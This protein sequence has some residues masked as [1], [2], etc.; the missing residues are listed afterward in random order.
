MLESPIVFNSLTLNDQAERDFTAEDALGYWY[1]VTSVDGVYDQDVRF[2]AHDL[3][4]QHGAKSGSAFYSGKTI[5]I[6]GE[7]RAVNLEKLRVAQ[8]ELQ[9]AF[10]DMQ[11][12]RLEF[13]LWE[14]EA[15]YI[16]CR[17]NQK[18]DMTEEQDTPSFLRRFTIQLFADDPRMYKQEGDTVYPDWS[19]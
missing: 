13:T 5:V 16:T 9:H 14:E 15:V 7:V 12:H 1:R 3:P 17:K 6:S 8:R 18:I 4:Q 11:P 19:A 2:E 10:Y